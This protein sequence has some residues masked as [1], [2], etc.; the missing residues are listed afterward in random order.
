MQYAI[1]QLAG[2]QYTVRAGDT[3]VTNTVDTGEKKT[4]KVT[5]VLF[6][7]DDE[8]KTAGSVGTPVVAGASVTLAVDGHGKG[9]KI[10]VLKYKSK[11]RYRK[12]YGHRQPQT[13]FT[14]QSIATK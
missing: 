1:I 4:L 5:D 13:T 12:V 9:K 2:K 7:G 11:S 3:L 8:K 10:R 14:V 6:V